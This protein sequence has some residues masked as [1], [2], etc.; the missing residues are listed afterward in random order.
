MTAMEEG[1]GKGWWGAFSE[2]LQEL[3]LDAFT[4]WKAVFCDFRLLKRRLL[5]EEKLDYF[6]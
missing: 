6:A 1:A 5:L 2:V 4:D 3:S